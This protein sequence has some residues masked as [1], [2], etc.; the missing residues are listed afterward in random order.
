MGFKFT[1]N[2][3]GGNKDTGNWQYNDAYREAL[4]PQTKRMNDEH[5]KELVAEWKMNHPATKPQDMT[6]AA[7]NAQQKQL[8]LDWARK[9]EPKRYLN[10]MLYPMNGIKADKKMRRRNGNGP[11]AILS[12]SWIGDAAF[13]DT[14]SRMPTQVQIELGG[15]PYTF[16]LNEIGGFEGLQKAL[17]APSIGSYIA[18]NWIGKLPSSKVNW[19]NGKTPYWI[20][21]ANR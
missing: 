4:N 20:K 3:N 1:V 16:K 11:T 6:S 21:K 17:S 13:N 10:P 5:L 9:M 14:A 2:Y 18:S 8:A 19:E 12:S 7:F 15:K